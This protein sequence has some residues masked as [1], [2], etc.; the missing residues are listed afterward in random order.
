[1]YKLVKILEETVEDNALM[2]FSFDHP[3]LIKGHVLIPL[4]PKH[5]LTGLELICI[6]EQLFI[7][8]MVVIGMV[9]PNV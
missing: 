2:G 9:V 1:M 4:R 8:F 3:D 5:A 7:N 6:K